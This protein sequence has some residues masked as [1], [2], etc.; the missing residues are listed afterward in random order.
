[1]NEQL[2][3]LFSLPQQR[4]AIKFKFRGR[5]GRGAVPLFITLSSKRRVIISAEKNHHMAKIVLCEFKY[6]LKIAKC[7]C[8]FLNSNTL[9]AVNRTWL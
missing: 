8:V 7:K 5:D 2:A 3:H 4:I 6:I 1:M 9:R